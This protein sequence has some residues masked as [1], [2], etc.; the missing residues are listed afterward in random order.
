MWSACSHS[1]QRS[2]IRAWVR[3]Y[4]EIAAAPVEVVETTMIS[5]IENTPS[6]WL[7]EQEH[8]IS[9]ARVARTQVQTMRC[10]QSRLKT[11]VSAPENFGSTEE[12]WEPN[13]TGSIRT[14][15]WHFKCLQ[16]CCD[17]VSH[18]VH[19]H[20]WTD[21]TSYHDVS[22]SMTAITHRTIDIE[23]RM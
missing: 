7:I 21:I 22:C 2:D 23:C 1:L 8:T 6:G 19:R 20:I 3:V 14:T 5:T 15:D 11:E 17:R 16:Y 18:C 4:A 10:R 9:R 13:I 12:L